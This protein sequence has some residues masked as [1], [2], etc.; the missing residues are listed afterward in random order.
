LC[1]KGCSD[2]KLKLWDLRQRRCI[3]DYGGSD[4]YDTADVDYKEFHKDSIWNIE[5][6][7]SFD[8]CF[9]GGRDG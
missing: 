2:S 1:L 4:V 3:R 6:S 9:T 5:P 7:D 8:T